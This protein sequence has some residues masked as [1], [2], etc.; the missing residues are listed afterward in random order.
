VMRRFAFL[1]LFIALISTLFAQPLIAATPPQAA[2]TY[3]PLNPL[4]NM[5]MTF[6]GSPSKAGGVGD[7]IV[8]FQWNFGDGS[9]KVNTPNNVTTHIFIAPNAYTVTLNVTN[10]QGLWNTT[11]QN[12]TVFTLNLTVGTSKTT[13]DRFDTARV[14]GTFTWVP[15]SYPVMEALVGVEVRNPNGSAFLFRTMPTSA[16]GPQSY[17][18][19]FNHF[20]TC[21]SNQVPKTSFVVG[22]DIWIYAEWQNFD[23]TQAY[24]VTTCIAALDSNS[25]PI[26]NAFSYFTVTLPGLVSSVL[27]RATQIVDSGILGSVVLY[28]NL[29]SDFPMNGGYP[30]CP[31]STATLTISPSAVISQPAT[32]NSALEM[33]PP[34]GAYDVSFKFPLGAAVV[35]N[36]TVYASSFYYDRVTSGKVNFTLFVIGDINGDG[37]VDIYDAISLSNAYNSSPGKSNWNPKADFNGD[38]FVDIYDAIIL[39][40]HY[41]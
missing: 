15:G 20:Y 2:F 10:S 13:Y 7:T 30:Y 22:Q 26:G 14:N 18:V 39:A 23:A 19:H 37:V 35:G 24:N 34:D 29:F 41:G 40:N 9:P 4:V 8:N 1:V 33:A 3:F 16:M 38:G 21:D 28:G 32:G 5:N 31:E 25:A 12:I 17:Q 36:Y 6:D 27:F 11:S